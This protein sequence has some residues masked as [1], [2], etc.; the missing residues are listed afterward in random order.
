[1]FV[2]IDP[3]SYN[4]DPAQ[5]E[6]KTTPRT[7]AIMPVHLYGQMADMDPIREIAAR[8]NLVVIEEG[9]QAIG[10]EY[11]GCRAGSIGHYGCFSFLPSKNLSGASEGGDG[12]D[13]R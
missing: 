12:R 11:K 3:V 13:D 10:A 2:D 7:K 4:I 8:Y 6:E 9:A 1:V 5:I